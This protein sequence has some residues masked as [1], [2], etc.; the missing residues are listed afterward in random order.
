MKFLTNA[1]LTG[2]EFE[3]V[4]RIQFTTSSGGQA[5]QP[6]ALYWAP[7]DKTLSLGTIGGSSIEIGQENVLPIMNQTGAVIPDGAVVGYDGALG[8]SGIIKGKLYTANGAE[9][10]EYLLGIATHNIPNGEI[11]HVATFGKLRGLNTTGTPYGETWVAGD[12]LWAHPTVSGGL[13]KVKPTAPHLKINMAAVT[14]V[15]ATQGSVVIRAT[16]GSYLGDNHNSHIV[17]LANNDILVY[18]NGNSRWEN[19]PVKTINGENIFGSGDIELGGGNSSIMIENKST[20]T[21]GAATD[22]VAIG[23]PNFSVSTHSLTVF[24]NSTYI[25]DYVITGTNIVKSSGTWDAGTVFNFI[26]YTIGELPDG[27]E[28]TTV[29]RQEFTATSGQTIFNLTNGSYSP[30]LNLIRVYLNGVRQPNTAYAET[31]STRITLVGGVNAGD[32]VL[33]EWYETLLLPVANA[34]TA[35]HRHDSDYAT[36]SHDHTVNQITNFPTSLPANGGNANAAKHLLGDDTR[37]INSPP[38]DYMSSGARYVDKVGN[39]I[40]FKSTTSL[41]VGA[42]LTGTYCFLETK[43]PWS[44]A[45]GGYPIQIAYGDGTPCYRVGT[46]TAT[47]GAWKPFFAG[48]VPS[49]GGTISGNLVVTGQVQITPTA[50]AT[51]GT[52]AL[53][54]SGAAYRTQAALTGNVTYTGSNYAAGR[55]ITIRVINGA[56]LRT[57]TFPAGWRFIGTKPANIAASKVGVLTITSFGTT[58]ADC[59]AAWAVEA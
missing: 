9:P 23:I 11:G 12:I 55:S 15:H 21:V 30:G 8:A 10:A 48:A 17:N 32:K 29:K 22:T 45:S 25:S 2:N 58:E 26:S 19:T 57:L 59:V 5:S 14:A 39:Q 42:F 51:T 37:A 31:N 44:D 34:A 53:D 47:W 46:G 4:K 49:T 27:T 54:F 50:L 28:T 6:G 20:T 1:N 13:T 38:S 3:N 36:I 35:D 33:C 40:E 43:N 7:E 16:Y 24:A 52:V 18:N 56:T 41:G